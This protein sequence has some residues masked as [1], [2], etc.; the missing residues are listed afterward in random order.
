MPVDMHEWQRERDKRT[1]LKMLDGK[2]GIEHDA[3]DARYDPKQFRGSR[4]V[5]RNSQMSKTAIAFLVIGTL[6]LYATADYAL[7]G[8]IYRHI[9]GLQYDKVLTGNP[10]K[11]V[12][13]SQPSDGM[14]ADKSLK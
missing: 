8:K 10:I 12:M 2:D 13:P 14:K 9:S 5:N 7:K 11:E 3:K 1:Y 6:L 4:K